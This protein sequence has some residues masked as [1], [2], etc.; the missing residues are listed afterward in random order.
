QPD[1]HERRSDVHEISFDEKDEDSTYVL[2]ASDELLEL[3]GM[4]RTPELAKTPEPVK[5]P[6]VVKAPESLKTPEP[7]K[8]P[9]PVNVANEEEEKIS[10][11]ATLPDPAHTPQR[12]ATPEPVRLKRQRAPTPESEPQ[13]AV[14]LPLSR[15]VRNEQTIRFTQPLQTGGIDRLLRIAAARGA[16]R[17]YLTSQARPSIR[18]DGEISAIEGESVLAEPDVEALILDIIPE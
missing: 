13:P 2:N 10:E 16:S 12:A 18:V 7:A 6:E 3:P 14:V 8:T 9:E 4:P 11:A 5:A 1:V 15:T 17:L